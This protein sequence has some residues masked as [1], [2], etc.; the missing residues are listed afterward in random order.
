[1]NT[2]EHPMAPTQEKRMTNPHAGKRVLVVEDDVHL[3]SGIRDILKLE[4]YDVQIAKNGQEALNLLKRN[5]DYPPDIIVSDIM[6]PYM[7]GFELLTEV[8]KEDRW[9]TVPFIFLTAKGEREDQ[10]RGRQLGADIYL[11]KP[12]EAPDLLIAVGAALDRLDGIR[13]V[14]DDEMMSQKRKILTILNH[15][16]RTPLTLV[17]AYAE[18]LKDYDKETADVPDGDMVSFL[19]GVFSGADRLRRL[20]ENFI[21]LVELDSGEAEKTITWRKR[22]V[23]DLSLLAED[24]VRQVRT[25][26]HDREHTFVVDIADAMPPVLLDVQYMTIAVRELLDNAC[27]FSEAGSTVR[28]RIFSENDECIIQVA[29]EGRGLP[30][31]EYEKVWQPFYQIDREQHEDQG[32]GSGLAIVA[33]VTE[34]HNGRYAVSSVEDEGSIFTLRLPQEG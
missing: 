26:L 4:D 33:G 20:I 34:L 27:K 11:T 12:F 23:D 25:A 10:N 14:K 32:A 22:P 30:T 15:E 5:P 29:D 6:M 2:Y 21:T 24:A 17:V 13:R 16:F 1:M 9:V 8:R 31:Q 28:L 19:R 7:N 3:L 18:M